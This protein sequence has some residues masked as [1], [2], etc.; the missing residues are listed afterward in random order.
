MAFFSVLAAIVLEHV[1]PLRQPLP[2]YQ[3]YTLFIHWLERK[4]NAGEYSH[5]VIAWT[6]AVGPALVGVWL[7]FFVLG[8]ISMLG[9]LKW[10][11]VAPL[12]LALCFL[13]AHGVRKLP[14]AREVL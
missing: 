14:L 5:G 7:I 3:R 6:L 1:R 8:G 2:H 10:L 4:L 12:A 13:L 11:W 9:L